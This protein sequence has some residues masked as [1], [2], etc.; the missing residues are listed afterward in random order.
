VNDPHPAVRELSDQAVLAQVSGGFGL[1]RDSSASHRMIAA[2]R[3]YRGAL[4]ARQA[5]VYRARRA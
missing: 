3:E 4:P 1:R 5:I 2:G